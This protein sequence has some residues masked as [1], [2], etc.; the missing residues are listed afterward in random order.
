MYYVRYN[1]APAKVNERSAAE[2]VADH[3]SFCDFFAD[4]DFLVLRHL[5]RINFGVNVQAFEII[6]AS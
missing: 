1:L 6:S 2:A 4:K 5:L 3:I